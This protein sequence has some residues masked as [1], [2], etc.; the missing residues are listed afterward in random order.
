MTIAKIE[1]SITKATNMIG[2]MDYPLS[3]N[4]K[5]GTVQ[6]CPMPCQRCDQYSSKKMYELTFPI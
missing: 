6:L 5:K 3:E 1:N 4:L 2:P